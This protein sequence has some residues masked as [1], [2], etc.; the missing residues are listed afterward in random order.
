MNENGTTR[1]RVYSV[2]GMTCSHCVA[3][4]REEVAEVG[5]VRDVDVDLDAGRLVVSGAGFDDEAVKTAVEEAGYQ[6]AA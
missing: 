6:L 3:S 4:V 5:G 2:V 1:S